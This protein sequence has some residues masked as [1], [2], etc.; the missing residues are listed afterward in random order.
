M[1]R[2]K[3][4]LKFLPLVLL[5]IGLLVILGFAIE[6]NNGSDC[7]SVEVEIAYQNGLQFVDEAAILSIVKRECGNLTGKPVSQIHLGTIEKAVLNNPFVQN[8]NV[9]KTI[10]GKVK[11]E[12]KQRE[13]LLRVFNMRG[14]DFYIDRQGFMMPVSNVYTARVPV[15][16]GYIKAGYSP[17]M[18]LSLGYEAHEV[19]LSERVIKDLYQLARFLENDAF[20]AAWFHQIY[21]NPSGEFELVSRCGNHIVE[22]GNL[23]FLEARMNKLMVFYLNGLPKAGWQKYKRINLKFKNQIVCSK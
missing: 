11:L 20:W 7:Q 19:A 2:L 1:N 14:E 5:P 17:S 10:G 12:V 21:V 15:V 8:V 4:I 18:N 23:D 13:P 6:F 3:K 22:L 9:Y 16:T